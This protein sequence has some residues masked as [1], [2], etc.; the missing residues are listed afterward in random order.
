[1]TEQEQPAPANGWMEISGL[2]HLMRVP[3]ISLQPYKVILGTVGVIA[4]FLLGWILDAVWLSANAGVVPGAVEAYASDAVAV[5]AGAP[6]PS[7]EAVGIFDAW[8]SF[9]KRRTIGLMVSII[10]GL[11]GSE[12]AHQLG[13]PGAGGPLHNLADM[14]RGVIWMILRHPLY[15]TLFLVGSLVIWSVIGG[16]ICRMAAVQFARWEKLGGPDAVS[17]VRSRLDSFLLAPVLPIVFV[18]MIALLLVLG[19]LV[20]RIPLLGDLVGGGLFFLALL[21]GAA[22]ACLL[23]GLV[24]GG[25]LLWPSVAVEGTDL[26]DAFSRAYSYVCW[27]PLRA[28]W[29]AVIGAALT[30][31][32]WIVA[33]LLTQLALGTTRTVVGFGTMPFGWW[34]RGGEDNPVSKLSLVWP[35]PQTGTLFAAPNW[36]ELA[37]YEY[38]SAALIAL[39]VLIVIAVLWGFLASFFYSTSTI[40]YFLLRRDVEHADLE[41]VYAEPI[42]EEGGE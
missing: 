3:E 18:V 26:F 8:W 13:V 35:M 15:S 16:A 12:I 25:S 11:R 9:E 10:P 7:G 28:V 21:G 24:V 41:E 14:L 30:S 42:A 4:T 37:G 20:L 36:G 1:M 23:A 34:S 40:I 29:Y 2:R 32:C 39:Y 17:F 22:I 27:R 38:L 6:G 5:V 19:G 31:A 33:F